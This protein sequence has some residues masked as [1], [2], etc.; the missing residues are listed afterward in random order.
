MSKGQMCQIGT[1]IGSLRLTLRLGRSDIGPDLTHLA[2][3]HNMQSSYGK[4]E[5][6]FTCPAPF[7]EGRGGRRGGLRREPT[8]R[9]AATRARTRPR[10]RPSSG[11]FGSD[12]SR[13]GAR[14][15]AC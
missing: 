15:P 3:A 7:F 6:T 9:G 14:I 13:K 8:G 1:Y 2:F 10:S 5:K 4:I 11:S 12:A